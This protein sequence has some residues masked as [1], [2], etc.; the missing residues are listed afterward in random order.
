MQEEAAH[1]VW[2]VAVT[3]V[4][5]CIFRISVHRDESILKNNKRI[6]MVQYENDLRKDGFVNR[7]P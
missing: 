4:V 6:T 7:A 2:N 5:L 3:E 1:L